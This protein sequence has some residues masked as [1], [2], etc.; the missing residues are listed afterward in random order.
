MKQAL[1]NGYRV[2]ANLWETKH[3]GDPF[4][5][6]ILGM[7]IGALMMSTFMFLDQHNMAG[8]A[9]TVTGLLVS[10]AIAYEMCKKPISPIKREDLASRD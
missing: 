5:V 10:C 9:V 4:S 8:L 7:V 3:A 1:L 2:W 6:L